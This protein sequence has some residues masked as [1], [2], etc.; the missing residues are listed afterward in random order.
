[1]Q[2]PDI[3]GSLPSDQL[4]SL[5]SFE[6]STSPTPQMPIGGSYPKRLFQGGS[7]ASTCFYLAT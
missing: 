6:V 5:L 1:M 2:V 7:L 3:P 4:Y